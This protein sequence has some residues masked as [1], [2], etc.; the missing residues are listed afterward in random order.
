MLFKRLLPAMLTLSV[1]FI[2]EAGASEKIECRDLPAPVRT[3]AAKQK[4]KQGTTP[5]CEKLTDNGQTLYELKVVVESGRMREIV[6]HPDGKLAEF[7]E[8]SRLSEIPADARAGIEKAVASGE[9]LKVDIIHRDRT[10]LYEGEYR[11]EGAKKK[12]IVD[13]AGRIV[14]K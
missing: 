8:E 6:Y 13:A 12:V 3:A 1:C 4:T 11:L 5:S 10:I 14:A 2:A 9:L 7:E